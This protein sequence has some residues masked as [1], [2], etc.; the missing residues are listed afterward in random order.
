MERLGVRAG[1]QAEG[2]RGGV[3][4]RRSSGWRTDRW[5]HLHLDLAGW[6]VGLIT[7]PEGGGLGW[8]GLR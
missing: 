7:E 2:E 6:K 8:V 1:L 4:W 3:W 5:D